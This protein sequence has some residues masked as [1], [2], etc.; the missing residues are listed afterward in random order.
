LAVVVQVQRVLAQEALAE[1]TQVYHLQHLLV[2][3]EQV[4]IKFLVHLVVLV[5]VQERLQHQVAQVMQ[6]VIH[7]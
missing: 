1:L 2:A 4:I 6:E 5:V 7:L 3:V